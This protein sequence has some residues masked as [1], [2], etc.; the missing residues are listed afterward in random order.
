MYSFS[1]R[2]TKAD[3][4]SVYALVSIR[5]KESAVL[6]WKTIFAFA[7][8]ASL[9]LSFTRY[10]ISVFAE[11]E[12]SILSSFEFRSVNSRRT[13]PERNTSYFLIIQFSY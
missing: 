12:S 7:K 10:F 2:N 11:V 4:V 3:A 1:D 8:A 5:K 6:T 9:R 13:F